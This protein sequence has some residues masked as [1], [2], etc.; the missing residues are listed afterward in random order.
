MNV[1]RLF[2]QRSALVGLV[3]LLIIAFGA[4]FASSIAPYEPTQVLIGAEGHDDVRKREKPC[5]Y[6]LGCPQ[7]EPQH[8]MGLDGNVRDVF[9]RIV[10][11]SRISLLVG[12][13][14]VISVRHSG[15]HSRF[16]SGLCWRLD[17]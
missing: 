2:R 7:E 1:R 9:S 17:R 6:A 15:G 13:V 16:G 8:I 10:F 4:L 14:V 12:F 5:V 11:G 3:I